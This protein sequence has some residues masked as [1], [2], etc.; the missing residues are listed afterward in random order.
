[1]W[2]PTATSAPIRTSRK[3]RRQLEATTV[4]TAWQSLWLTMLALVLPLPASIP[5]VILGAGRGRGARQCQPGLAS[6]SV[7]SGTDS[8]LEMLLPVTIVVASLIS[9]AGDTVALVV[10]PAGSG[11]SAQVP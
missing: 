9:S 2:T 11:G 5:P 4:A 6:I 10:S 8:D 3:S 1:M 7:V